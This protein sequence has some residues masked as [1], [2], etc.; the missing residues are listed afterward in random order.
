MQ[1]IGLGTTL[2]GL[3]LLG[4]VGYLYGASGL[5]ENRTQSTLYASLRYQLSQ[6]LAPLAATTPGAPV[7]ILDI[8][9]IGITNM[10]VVEGTSPE[11]LTLGPGHARDTPLPGEFGV[12]QIFGRRATFGAPFGRLMQLKRGDAVSVITGQGTARYTVAAAG[13]SKLLVEDPAPNRLLLVSSCSA[14]VPTMYCYIDADLTTTPQQDPGGRPQLTPAEVPL[15]G[16][17]GALV[18]TLAWGLAL[19][20]VSAAATVG[21]AR[22]SPLAAY[23]A[24]APLVLAVLWNLYQSLAALLPNLY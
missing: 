23:L 7:A 5:Q 24:T 3:F 1:A 13:S 2:L 22:W 16:D 20:V 11:N 10:I 19:V 4:F 17:S 12:A 9:A 15:G 6:Q 18:L 21:A 8:P 14:Y